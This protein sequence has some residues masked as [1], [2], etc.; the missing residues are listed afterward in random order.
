MKKYD[1]MGYEQGNMSPHVED[2]QKPMKD[3][4]ESQF[5]KTLNYVERQ[6]RIQAKEAS[7]IKKQGYKG[8]YS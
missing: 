8:R 7:G 2:Y 6:D 3:F 1:R 4:A 5:S